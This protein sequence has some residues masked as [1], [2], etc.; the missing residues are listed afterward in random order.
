VEFHSGIEGSGGKVIK[1][2]PLSRTPVTMMMLVA[3]RGAEISD[4]LM[5]F[6]CRRELETW[7]LFSLDL[8]VGPDSNATPS[9]AL[10]SWRYI[11]TYVVTL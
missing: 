1:N 11:R 3:V 4:R 7:S 10:H 8:A 9:H 2:A 5:T 6:K